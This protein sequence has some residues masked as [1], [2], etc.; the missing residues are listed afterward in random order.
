[1]SY[2][3]DSSYVVLS[4]AEVCSLNIRRWWSSAPISELCDFLVKGGLG[5]GF[6]FALFRIESF[7]LIG[8]YFQNSFDSGFRAAYASW[9]I[10]W[11]L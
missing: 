7:Y 6:Y 5:L 11:S 9:G 1:M 2:S 8:A 10:I 4:S 3:T